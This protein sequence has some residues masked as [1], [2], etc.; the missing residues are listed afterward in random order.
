[1]IKFVDAIA[2]EKTGLSRV[3]LRNGKKEYLGM[4]HLAEGDDW[5]HI[6]GCSIAEIRATI[7]IINDILRDKRKD[8]KAIENFVKALECYKN[9]DENSNT[10]TCVYRQFNRKKI[11]IERLKMRR[12]ELKKYLTDSIEMRSNIKTKISN[13]RSSKNKDKES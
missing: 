1:M 12:A 6:F 9:F 10:A 3:W 13:M 5:S 8:L 4:A 7:R 2:D 11:E